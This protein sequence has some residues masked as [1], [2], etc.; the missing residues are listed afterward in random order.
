MLKW[1]KQWVK[2]IKGKAMGK[3]TARKI[4]TSKERVLV[5]GDGLRLIALFGLLVNL[6]GGGFHRYR[7]HRKIAQDTITT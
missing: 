3:L 4:A 6:G 5:D 1:V 7:N 2:D